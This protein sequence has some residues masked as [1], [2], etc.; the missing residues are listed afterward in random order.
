MADRKWLT[1][2]WLTEKW[3]LLFFCQPFFCQPFFCQPFFCQ[4]FFCQPSLS[5]P[6]RELSWPSWRAFERKLEAVRVQNLLRHCQ[7]DALTVT[8]RAEERREE[9]VP[10][11]GRNPAA[12]VFNDD[13]IFIRL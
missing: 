7:S 6:Y 9:I 10:R 13:D 8:F 3:H 1:E 11:G 4:P 5:K 12:G 2:K